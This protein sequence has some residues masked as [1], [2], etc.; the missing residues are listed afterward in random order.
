MGVETAD[1]LGSI[2]GHNI[3]VNP[4]GKVSPLCFASGKITHGGKHLAGGVSSGKGIENFTHA[5]E[6][7]PR[8]VIGRTK[9]RRAHGEGMGHGKRLLY[10]AIC[11]PSLARGD[12]GRNTDVY[13]VPKAL[14]G[15]PE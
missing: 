7:R 9:V 3:G 8:R 4:C 15:S 5:R 11:S 12:N 13:A 2:C 14:A 10:V 6:R 1:S